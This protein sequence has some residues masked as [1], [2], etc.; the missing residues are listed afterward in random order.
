[1]ARIDLKKNTD[2]PIDHCNQ[3]SVL[4]NSLVREGLSALDPEKNNVSLCIYKVDSFDRYLLRCI[5]ESY[6]DKHSSYIKPTIISD[7][8]YDHYNNTYKGNYALENFLI[9]G[10]S[11][12]LL[13]NGEAGIGKSTFMNELFLATALYSLKNDH[14]VL[15]LYFHA[16][17]FGSDD[18][19]P[20]EWIEHSLN[21]R[22]E[23]MNFNPAFFNPNVC[24][25]FFIDAINDIPFSSY[26][27]FE[28]KLDM[29]QQYI[30][31]LLGRYKNIKVVISSRYLDYLRNFEIRNYS[32]LFIQALDDSQLEKF[33]S[34]SEIA[35]DKKN[36][37]L[38]FIRAN[39]E[40]HFLRIPFFLS[41]IL[42]ASIDTL[43]NKTEIINTFIDSI[44]QK[45]THFI[46][47]RKV[48]YTELGK[49]ISDVRLNGTTFLQAMGE[50]AYKCQASG[51]LEFSTADIEHYVH[52]DTQHF[53]DIAINNSIF[54]KNGT[55]FA[56][57]IFQEYFAGRHIAKG[58]PEKYR[59]SDLLAFESEI[60]L[61][62]SLKHVYNFIS[63]KKQFIDILLESHKF[64]IAAECVLDNREKEL[65]RLVA[66]SICNSLQAKE[67]SN[68]TLNLGL[69]LGR[70]G[71]VRFPID[72]DQD[73]IPPTTYVSKCNLHVGIY[74]ITNRE[75]KFFVKDGGYSNPDYWT[76]LSEPW[77]N[78]EQKIQSICN[79]WYDIQSRL[80]RSSD[81]FFEFCFSNH[82]DKELIANLVFFKQISKED[83]ESMIRD[84]YSQEKDS[85]PLMWS[86]P[87]Y[88]NPSQPVVGISWF[89]ASAYCKWLSHKTGRTYRLLTSEE[90]EEVANAK[91]RAY[92]YG[93]RFNRNYSN[94]LETNLNTIAVVGVCSGN[95]TIEGV[96]DMSGNVFEWT[97]S[98]YHPSSR[99]ALYTQYI[100]KGGSWIQDFERS[101]SKYT[102]RGMAWVRNL[103]LG[104]R[105]CLDEN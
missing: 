18:C 80:N 64:E 43:D 31:T 83:L 102:G 2:P 7:G 52:E 1:M 75:Y 27:N 101:T 63:T 105:V 92:V 53:L 65:R 50:L 32:R 13:V 59:I 71:D 96:F 42:S 28:K 67:L 38:K 86:N 5:Y 22:Y 81:D 85:E 15:P 35:I 88:N 100:C 93:N 16:E 58:L 23:Y 19:K 34:T 98:V 24:V 76:G 37:L 95:S 20:E 89:E 47:E 12:V 4:I 30:N 21:N 82:F 40:M 6:S 97:S 11:D 103:D 57:S 74:P 56:H 72:K 3:C 94:T 84:L 54:T 91:R 78:R 44:F 33:I 17:E 104:F 49:I 68:E 73:F 14:C 48:T 69:L 51:C 45:S 60:H 46:R 87:V 66:Y 25:V 79:F 36:N 55:K 39:E 62:Q 90:W 29:W 10:D 9:N 41:K 61:C 77:F 8:K 26:Q 70:L 99:G